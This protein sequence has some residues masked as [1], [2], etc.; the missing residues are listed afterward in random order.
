MRKNMFK[1]T[2]LEQSYPKLRGRSFMFFKH[3]RRSNH[4]SMRVFYKYSCNNLDCPTAPYMF[5]DMTNKICRTRCSSTTWGD[6]NTRTCV[7]SCPWD[8]SMY[9]TYANPDT[10]QCV[11]SCPAFPIMYADNSTKSCVAICPTTPA[12]PYRTFADPTTRSCV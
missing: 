1:W 3:H 10:R 6:T 5:A 12:V 8:P 11:T 2:I 9:V 4:K 7:A